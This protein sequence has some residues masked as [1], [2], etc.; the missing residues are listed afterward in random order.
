M[1]AELDYGDVSLSAIID[2]ELVAHGDGAMH[3]DKIQVGGPEVS[4]AATSAQALALG[5]HELATN[6]V[7][8]GALAQPGGKL[9]VAW[10]VSTEG[11]QCLATIEWRESGVVMPKRDEGDRRGYG[12]ELITRALPYQLGAKTELTHR[13]EGVQCTITIPVKKTEHVG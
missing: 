9:T 1:L 11:P 6:A 12:T 8:Y 2:A 13:P 3:T 7:K 4:L 5:I 10:S